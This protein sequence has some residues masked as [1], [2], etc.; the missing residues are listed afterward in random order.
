MIVTDL[1]PFSIVNDLGF[2]HYSKL[3]HPRFT[4]ASDTYYRRLLEK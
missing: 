4:V 3:L 1:Q 2:L